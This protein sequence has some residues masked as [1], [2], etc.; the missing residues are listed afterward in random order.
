MAAVAKARP[1]GRIAWT[2]EAGANLRLALP[3]AI[4][5]LAQMATIFVDNVMVGRLGAAELAAGGLGSNLLFPP[6]LLGM[7]ILAGVAAIASHAFGAEDMAKAAVVA[8]QGLRVAFSLSIPCGLL[9]LLLAFLLPLGGYDPRTVSLAQGLLFWGLP[10]V[11]GFL[12]FSALR[13]FATAANRPNVV[14]VVAILSIGVTALCNYLFLYGNWGMPRLGV[15]AIGLTGSIVSWLEFLAVAAYLR[16][17]RRFRAFHVFANLTKADPAFREILR[18]GWPIAGS[19]L[20]ENGLFV[21]T[22]LLIG[23]FGNAALAATTVVNGLCSFTFMIPYAIGQAATVRVGR[24]LGADQGDAARLAG[25]VALALG[26]VWMLAAASLF[27]STPR[28]LVGLYVDIADPGNGAMLAVAL[29]LLPV[30]ALFQV[31]DGTQAVAGGALRGLK[32]TRVPMAICFV[33]Y[34]AIGISAGSLLGF[35]ADLGSVGLWI[36]LA[37]GLAAT[38]ILLTLRFWRLARRLKS[39]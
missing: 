29:S 9:L 7:G 32:D 15:P 20:F 18:I 8:R 11:P 33:G 12:A 22:T 2:T 28:F 37:L 4:A 27:L 26:V 1:Q 5:F 14:T 38:A 6:L 19:Y 10:G 16:L 13:Y 24:A 17:D 39:W 31:F 3:I 34:W 25:Y 35:A 36:G 21:A 23:V 30:A